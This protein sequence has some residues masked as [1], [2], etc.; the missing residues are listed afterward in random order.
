MSHHIV[1]RRSICF[2]L[3]TNFERFHQFEQCKKFVADT[4]DLLGDEDYFGLCMVSDDT[5][6]ATVN[7]PL[8]VKKKASA[9]KKSCLEELLYSEEL[10]HEVKLERNYMKAPLIDAIE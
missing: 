7:V 3:D 2:V 8:D 9:I 5:V 6:E 1:E 10:H 4:F